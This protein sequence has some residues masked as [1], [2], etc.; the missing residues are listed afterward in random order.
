MVAQKAETTVVA[1]TDFALSGATL[2]TVAAV[3]VAVRWALALADL[4]LDFAKF[5]VDKRPKKKRPFRLLRISQ[6]GRFF[7]KQAKNVQKICAKANLVVQPVG[8]Q[9]TG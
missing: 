4:F 5:R 7:D 2:L 3:V 8:V 1:A 6:N 9:K